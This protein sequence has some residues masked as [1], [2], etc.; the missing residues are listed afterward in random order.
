MNKILILGFNGMLG[1]MVS[2]YFEDL[3]EFEV[4]KT[5]RRIDSSNLDDKIYKFDV[6]QDS[7]ENLIEVTKPNYVINCIGV[8][9][10]DID[11]KNINSVKAA[12]NINSYFPLQ[13]ASLSE[14]FN[15]KYI[16]IGTDCVF[17]GQRGNYDESSFQDA[18]DVYGKTKVAGEIEQL[19]KFILRGSIVGPELGEGKSLLN[20]FLSEEGGEVSGFSD[21]SWNGITTLNFAKII[22]GMIKNN[23]FKNKINHIIPKDKVSKFELLNYFK[24]YFDVDV[25]INETSSRQIVDRT[26]NT[27]NISDNLKL[28]NDAGY[29]SIPTIEENIKELS[30]SNTTRAILNRT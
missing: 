10:P 9:K 19:G 16:Q 4:Y 2:E 26:L 28:W 12:I 7:L 29:E 30:E 5:S 24:I 23:N 18:S 8:I 22:H 27:L 17:S 14:D 3:H 11:E 20:W 15:F 1:T 21:H 25:Q 13:I 6:S